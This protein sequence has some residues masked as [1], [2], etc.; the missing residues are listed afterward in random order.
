[1]TKVL[2]PLIARTTQAAH[3]TE[4]P[5][6]APSAAVPAPA[7]VAPRAAPTLARPAL[8][9]SPLYDFDALN[10]SFLDDV[11]LMDEFA[12]DCSTLRFISKSTRS[13]VADAA[14]T[15]LRTTL[16]ASRGSLQEERAWKLLLL[17][18]R[19]LFWAPLRLGERK[20]RRRGTEDRD[21]GRLL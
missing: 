9:P 5:P 4:S 18:E 21:L 17:R 2:P 13:I 19:L 7:A 20:S 16:R 15:L 11:S 10:W 8:A 14:E 3:T 1:M 12:Q 6:R